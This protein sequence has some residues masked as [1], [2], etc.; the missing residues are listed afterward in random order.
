MFTQNPIRLSEEVGD[1]R[2]RVAQGERR[3][4]FARVNGDGDDVGIIG[5]DL[6]LW[7]DFAH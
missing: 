1:S 3:L 5:D 2:Q 4:G 7:V 6:S